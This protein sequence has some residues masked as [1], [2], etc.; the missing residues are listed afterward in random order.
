ML[1]VMRSNTKVILWI[2]VIGFLGFIF[3]GWGRGLQKYRNAAPQQGVVG[4]VDGTVITYRDFSDELS[5]RVRNYAEQSG[6]EVSDAARDALREETWNAMVADIIVNREIEKLHID[7]P[8][9]SIFDILWNNPPQQVY[10]SPSFQDADG[11]FDFDL[12]HREIQMHPERWEGIA[13]MYRQSLQ[14]QRLQQEIQAGAFVSDNEVWDEFAAQNEKV[15]VSYID[16]DPNRIDAASLMPT[17]EEARSYFQSHRADYE[18]PATAVLRYVAFP[19]VA[20]E[21]D[22]ADTRSYL[23]DLASVAREGE[24]FAELAKTYSQGPSAP[25]GGDLGWF[26][27]GQM[28][29]EFEDAA[30]A[31]GVGDVSDPVKTQFGY[32][33]IKVEDKR[34]ENGEEQIKARHILVKLAPS[35]ETLMELE[36]SANELEELAKKNGLDAAAAEL[37]YKPVATP[38]FVNDRM[39]PGVGEIRPAV[40]L[41]FENKPGFVFGPVSSTDAFYVFEVAERNPRTLPTYDELTEQAQADGAENPAALDL[42]R[43][44]RIDSG[45]AKAERIADAVRAGSTLEQAAAAE[46]T[47]VQQTDLFSRRDYVRRIGRANEFIGAS[48]GLRAGET[49][50]VISSGDPQHFYVLRV[51][52]KLAPDRDMFAEQQEQLRAQLLRTEQIDLFTAWLEGLTAQAK[53]DDYRERYF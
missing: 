41:T 33:I 9:D 6:A 44:R 16:I 3:A 12:Y 2:V 39:I 36:D 43:Q 37:G 53:I 49:S 26:G 34:R 42:L 15:R 21:A 17:D 23:A 20:S 46:E 48:F 24:D 45:R 27:R 51:E 35:E 13:Q 8:D 11:N 10:N 31:L 14:R 32:H 40:V 52:E 4:R 22:E 1:A 38:P 19:K 47:S 29:P 50:G 5:N 7:V 25:D 30:F 28:V 18:Q